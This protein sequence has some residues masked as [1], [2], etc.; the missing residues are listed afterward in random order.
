[1]PATNTYRGRLALETRQL[2]NVAP[3][4]AY[5]EHPALSARA[6][7]TQSFSVCALTQKASVRRVGHPHPCEEDARAPMGSTS[8]AF[9]GR[10]NPLTRDLCNIRGK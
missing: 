6:V 10:A 9:K 8:P 2:H 1:M 4:L 7:H 5:A 3:Q